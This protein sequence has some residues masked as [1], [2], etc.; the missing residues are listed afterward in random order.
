MRTQ[1]Q[2]A[3]VLDQ[4]LFHGLIP[5]HIK[6]LLE[7]EI[8]G[9]AGDPATTAAITQSAQKGSTSSKNQSGTATPIAG[10]K[11]D[12]PDPKKQAEDQKK[13]AQGTQLGMQMN[14]QDKEILQ[15]QAKI[16]GGQAKPADVTKLNTLLTA[17]KGIQDQFMKNYGVT[18]TA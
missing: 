5:S 1:Q 6:S 13:Q 11:A 4:V 18:P 9:Q 7:D 3:T 12:T 2:L 15:L 17:K 8:D 10:Q 16:T 14:R